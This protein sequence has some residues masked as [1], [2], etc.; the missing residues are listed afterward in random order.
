[1]ELVFL[2]TGA[3]FPSRERN[4]SAC[5][6]NLAAERGSLW[7]FDCG[8]GTQHRFLQAGL[9]L[10]RIEKIF[11]THL[12]GDHLFGL[13]GLLSTRSF[14]GGT[15]PITVYGPRPLKNYLEST[16][17]A[18]GTYIPAS[19]AV[20]EI[21]EGVIFADDRFTVTAGGLCHRVPS[22]GFRIAEKDKPGS[23][24]A[25]KLKA[26]GIPAGPLFQKLKRGQTVTLDGGR[27]VNGHDFL[28]PGSKGKIVAILGDTE[29]CPGQRPLAEGADVLVHEATYD[30][31]M[32][33]QARE[34]GHSTNAQAA[35]LARE[36]GVGRLILTHLSSRYTAEASDAMAVEAR[37]IFPKTEIAS[38]LAVF[39]V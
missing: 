35:A 22:F 9:K 37:E 7:L 32:A 20:V 13:P 15:K 38:D 34:H 2:G 18:S 36:S 4:V 24:N 27:T 19:L 21:D 6:L 26:Q 33:D 1:M 31:S 23:L 14:K 8:E 12:H 5:V 17:Q 3:G 16:F 11:I 10:N 39:K 25:A 30:T 28:S 29:I